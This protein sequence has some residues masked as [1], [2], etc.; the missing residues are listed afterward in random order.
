MVAGFKEN[1]GHGEIDFLAA[2]HQ[3]LAF[4]ARKRVQQLI[5]F[6]STFDD[7]QGIH[8]LAYAGTIDPDPTQEPGRVTG[9]TTRMCR[10]FHVSVGTED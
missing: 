7:W 2:I 1:F 4:P 8:P 3:V 6:R 5:A 10:R 9:G